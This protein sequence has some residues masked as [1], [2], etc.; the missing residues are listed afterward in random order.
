[1]REENEKRGKA[2]GA[3]ATARKLSLLEKHVQPAGGYPRRPR[4]V[5]DAIPAPSGGAA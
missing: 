3:L 2:E 5:E 1:V 4:R